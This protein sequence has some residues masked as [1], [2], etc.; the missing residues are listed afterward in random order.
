M[1][2]LSLDD[3]WGHFRRLQFS[4]SRGWNLIFCISMPPPLKILFVVKKSKN[5]HNFW[6]RA[7]RRLLRS[8]LEVVIFWSFCDCNLIFST[9]W[10]LKL[11]CEKIYNFMILLHKNSFTKGEMKLIFR[12]KNFSHLWLLLQAVFKF[13]LKKMVSYHDFGSL[14]SVFENQFQRRFQLDIF[15]SQ[16]RSSQNDKCF[17][18]NAPKVCLVEKHFAFFQFWKLWNDN[19]Q[20]KKRGKWYKFFLCDIFFFLCY[21]EILW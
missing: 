8:F 1:A 5:G 15:F 9:S 12:M 14:P 4:S 16:N 10:V 20:N 7:L 17:L 13:S 11:K 21:V 6:L 2:R 3:F 19:F 18:K